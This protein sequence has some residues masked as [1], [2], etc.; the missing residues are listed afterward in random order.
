MRDNSQAAS[1]QPQAVALARTVAARVNQTIAATAIAGNH[2]AHH[3]P[4]II[5]SDCLER[6][7]PDGNRFSAAQAE[8]Y[9]A[10]GEQTSQRDNECWNVDV[11]SQSAL[12]RADNDSNRDSRG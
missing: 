9:A 3:W 10:P 4:N 11:G 6:L 12:H 5:L 1:G 7:Q 8:N 2:P